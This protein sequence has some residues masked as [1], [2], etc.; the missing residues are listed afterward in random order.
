MK[1]WE[2]GKTHCVFCGRLTYEKKIVDQKIMDKLGHNE[3]DLEWSA[4]FFCSHCKK[5]FGVNFDE[6]CLFQKHED[7]KELIK[8]LKLSDKHQSV[9]TD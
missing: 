2:R 4:M 5:G 3:D 9:L 8:F 1:Y 6:S 7:D